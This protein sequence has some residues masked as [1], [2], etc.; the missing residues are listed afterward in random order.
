MRYLMNS[1]P[2]LLAGFISVLALL[3]LVYFIYARDGG[4]SN[5]TPVRALRFYTDDDGKTWFPDDAT[6]VPPFERD[7]RQ[8]VLARVYRSGDK[9]FVNHMER[10]TAEGKKQLENI[11]A[12]SPPDPMDMALIEEIQLSSLEVKA[13]G[14]RTWVKMTHPQAN[15]I[16]LPQGSGGGSAVELVTP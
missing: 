11:L 4:G 10:Y 9:E 14:S 2:R 3:A 5:G 15:Q 6:K 13:R 7:G 16:M 1:A 12:K 8:A